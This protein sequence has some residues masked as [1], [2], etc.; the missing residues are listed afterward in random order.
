MQQFS[1]HSILIGRIPPVRAAPMTPI[2]E[3]TIDTKWM[4]RYISNEKYR[5]L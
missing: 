4:P 2:T 1:A 5:R 3:F